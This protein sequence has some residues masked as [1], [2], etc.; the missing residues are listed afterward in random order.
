MRK[1]IFGL[2]LVRVVAIL[3][4]IIVHVFLHTYFVSVNL[5][6][7]KEFILLG[8]RNLTLTCVPLFILLTGYCKSEKK[9]NKDHYKSLWKILISYLLIAIITILYKTLYLG[10]VFDFNKYILGIL[11]FD[12]NEYAW[13][14]EMYIGLFLLI[15]FLNILYKGIE[16]RQQKR[17]LI[18]SLLLICSLPQ[19][20]KPLMIGKVSLDIMPNWWKYLY[21]LLYYF[22]GCYIKEY[23]IT[24]KKIPNLLWIFGLTLA[25]T[26]FIFLFVHKS[27]MEITGV[28]PDYYS[29]FTVSI[30]V[31]LFLFLYQIKTKKHYL[32]KTM[33]FISKNTLELYLLSYIFDSYYY[34]V[35]ITDIN[36][37]HSII[38]AMLICVPL[39]FITSLLSAYVL[40][41]ITSSIMKLLGLKK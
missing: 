9:A 23:Q 17:V 25:Q 8:I 6:G 19:T 33:E 29:I 11:R 41:M 37:G 21:P 27:S 35:F 4:V 3:F 20:L 26:I 39:V 2:D 1:R 38:V 16:T 7:P 12:V 30:S 10:K 32:Q 31:M 24:M 40:N 13:Y 14:L 5:T 15:P 18:F 34:K 36:P 28:I 22:L